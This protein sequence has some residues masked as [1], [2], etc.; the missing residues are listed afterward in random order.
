LGTYDGKCLG[1]DIPVASVEDTDFYLMVEGLDDSSATC[2]EDLPLAYGMPCSFDGMGVMTNPRAGKLVMCLDRIDV[3]SGIIAE[4]Q[5]EEVR[6]AQLAEIA[7]ALGALTDFFFS[8]INPKTGMSYGYDLAPDSTPYSCNDGSSIV[9]KP[10]NVFATT[11]GAYPHKVNEV[12]M[13]VSTQVAKNLHN[14]QEVTGVRLEKQS[15][16]GYLIGSCFG[17]YLDARLYDDDL[18][19]STRTNVR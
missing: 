10:R 17:S 7:H 12:R 3:K 11:Y 16:D 14:C 1:S 13:P 9:L 19:S 2:G 8:Y 4:R 6:V 5:L 18:L 15:T